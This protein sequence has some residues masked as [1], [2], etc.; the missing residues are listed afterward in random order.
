MYTHPV[1]KILP[2][3]DYPEELRDACEIIYTSL[4]NQ[5]CRQSAKSTALF[6]DS[7]YT[8]APVLLPQVETLQEEMGDKAS[9]HFKGAYN[10]VTS[11][12]ANNTL[13]ESIELIEHSPERNT[14]VGATARNILLHLKQ[15]SEGFQKSCCV[16][17]KALYSYQAYSELEGVPVCNTCKSTR[18]PD[19]IVTTV[20]FV[21]HMNGTRIFPPLT[22][23]LRIA[24]SKQAETIRS[25]NPELY[26][27][28]KKFYYH[29]GI[30]E[31][32]SQ[33]SSNP[34]Y[35]EAAGACIVEFLHLAEQYFY[36]YP[37][38]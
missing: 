6:S 20:K 9:N 38:E 16:C 5:I 31:G 24:T 26:E 17:G 21:H 35:A 28:A 15:K 19:E 33:V 4:Y 36:L 27:T 12:L 7:T 25:Y 14:F 13:G 32:I 2:I 10:L 23:L 34:C 29:F 22:E 3:N 1:W 8:E 11:L 37:E 18:T 30:K